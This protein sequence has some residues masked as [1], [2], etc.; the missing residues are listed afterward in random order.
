M[1]YTHVKMEFQPVCDEHSRLL[2]LGS[3]PSVKSREEKGYACIMV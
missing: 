3:F 2:I 1:E